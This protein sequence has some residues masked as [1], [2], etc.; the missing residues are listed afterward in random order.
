MVHVIIAIFFESLIICLFI[1]AIISWI[2]NIGPGNPIVRFFTTIT[3]PLIEPVVKRLPHVGMGMFD[4]TY[5]IAFFFVWWVLGI[6]Q[7]LVFQAI[8]A[9]W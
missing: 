1:S 6:L 2:P 5:T 7:L 3:A 8:P 9:S 4:L